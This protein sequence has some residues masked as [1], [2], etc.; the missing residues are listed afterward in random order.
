MAD[1]AAVIGAGL[2]GLSCARSLVRRGFDV[3]VYERH[4]V[5]TPL[6]GSPGATRIY[7]RTY[8]DPRYVRLARAA[9]E[10]WRRLDP[11]LLLQVGLLETGHG[12]PAVSAA[13][14]GCGEDHELLEPKQATGL[15]PE[16]SFDGPVLW[17]SEAGAV[18]ASAAL[19]TLARGLDIREGVAVTEPRELDADVVVVCAGAWLEQLLPLPVQ[20]QIEQVSYLRAPAESRPAL[21]DWGAAPGAPAFF[22]LSTPG[23]GYKLAEDWGRPGRWDADRPDRPVDDELVRRL[24]EFARARLPGLDSAPIASEACLY[25]VTPDRNFVI[26]ELDGLYVCGGDS[27]HAFKFGP[28]LGE[29]TA[30]LA[31]GKPLPDDAEIFAPERFTAA[32]S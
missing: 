6:G 13:L 22:G 27:G 11:Q 2:L 1:R 8:D 4:Q 17:D 12:V 29:L 7:R 28:L 24:S 15:F 10:E 18:R 14:D 23:V 5:G 3:V 31:I 19:S 30:D 21:I 26:G 25:A 32:E 16:A 20:P 9:I